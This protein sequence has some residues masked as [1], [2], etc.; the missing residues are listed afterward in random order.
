MILVK[1][2]LASCYQR[3]ERHIYEISLKVRN[4][5]SYFWLHDLG[6]RTIHLFRFH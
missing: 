5:D 4:S 6:I 3:C 2:C 1:Y